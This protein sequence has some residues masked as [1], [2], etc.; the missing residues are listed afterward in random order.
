MRRKVI[1]ESIENVVGTGSGNYGD[2]WFRH[3]FSGFIDGEGSFQIKKHRYVYKGE[4]RFSYVP[5][6][7]L[8]LRADDREVLEMIVSMLGFGTIY[9][10]KVG[11]RTSNPSVRLFI[12]GKEPLVRLVRLLTY[13]SATLHSK[14]ARDFGIW[15]KA[16]QKWAYG[17]KISGGG[18]KALEAAFEELIAVRKFPGAA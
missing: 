13:P 1:T 9:E 11:Q 17:R 18:T 2:R 8:G 7:S 14:K 6:F 12:M 3:W 5:I 16:I 15:S 4:E 10:E